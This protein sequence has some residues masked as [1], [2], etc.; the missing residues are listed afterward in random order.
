[1]SLRVH[2]GF[3]RAMQL[4]SPKTT[5]VTRPTLGQLRQKLFNAFQDL[6]GYAFIDLF[7]GTGSMGIEAVSNGAKKSLFIEKD[8]RT[9]RALEKNVNNLK[10]RIEADS[11]DVEISD[12]KSWKLDSMKWLKQFLVLEQAQIEKQQLDSLLFVDPPYERKDL[13]RQT[14]SFIAEFKKPMMVWIESDQQKGLKLTDLERELKSL[15]YDCGKSYFQ[16]SSFIA[17]A[18]I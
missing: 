18:R 14:L 7:A 17:I 10:A 2:S 15:G 13:Y 1:M 11:I 4:E 12:L 6:N 8:G 9:F 5:K 16:G 3:A